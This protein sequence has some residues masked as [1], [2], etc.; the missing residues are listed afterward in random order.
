[1]G[2]GRVAL[3]VSTGRAA[4]FPSSVGGQGFLLVLR[5]KDVARLY[6]SPQKRTPKQNP[7]MSILE[8]QLFAFKA[9]IIFFLQLPFF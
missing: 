9:N 7:P 6:S 3:A 4:W 1:M 5:Q 2:L 8:V